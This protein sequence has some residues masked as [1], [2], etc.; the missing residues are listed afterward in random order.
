MNPEIPNRFYRISVKALI[1]DETRTKFLV[2]QEPDGRWELPGGGIDW[3]ELVEDCMRRELKEEMG[4]DLVSIKKSPSYFFTGITTTSTRF[5]NVLF[6]VSTNNLNFTPSNECV[7]L[8]FVTP[9]EAKKLNAF[10]SVHMLADMFD[11]ANHL[12]PSTNC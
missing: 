8:Q 10:S 12:V 6:E 4:L 7:A 11:P 9:E 3:D 1:L 2:V 5:A